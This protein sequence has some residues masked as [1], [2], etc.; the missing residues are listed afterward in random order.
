MDVAHGFGMLAVGLIA[1]A[2]ASTMIFL[3]IKKIERNKEDEAEKERIK[4][5]Y[6]SN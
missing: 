4:K 3:V 1:I 6:G 2:V 5:F